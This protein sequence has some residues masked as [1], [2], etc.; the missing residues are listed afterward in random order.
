M[1]RNNT[2]AA[3]AA[4]LLAAPLAAQISFG[5]RPYGDKAEKRGMPP[6]VAVHLPAVDVATLLNEDA[7]RAS[8]GIKGPFR[9]GFEH[10]TDL[11]MANSG[12]WWTM[13]NGDRVWRVVLHCPEALTINLQFSNYVLPEGAR[14][15]IY[16]EAGEVKGAFTAQSNP[17]HTAFGTVPLAGDRQTVEYIEPANSAEHGALTISTVIHGYRLLGKS[18]ERSFGNSG[19]CNVNT[20]CPEGDDWR[21]EIRAVAHVILGGGVCSGSLVNNC[22]NDSTPYFLTA[23]HCTG[24]NN[25][26]AS[27]VFVF[28]WESPACTPTANAPMDHSIT[29]CD[30][31][32]ENPPTDASF[33][34]LSTRPPANFHPYYSGWDKSGSIPDTVHCIHH[35]SGDIK[36]ISSSNGPFDA[37]NVNVGNGPADCWHVPQWNSGT[38]EPGSSGSSLWNQDHR[39][40][41]QLYGGQ[42]SCNNNVNDFFGRFDSTYQH[43]S[44]WLGACGQTLDGLDPEL[45]IP[46][47]VDAAITSITHVDRVLCN[48]DSVAP[49]VTLKNNGTAVI[50]SAN[51]NYFINGALQGTMPWYGALQPVQTVNVNLPAIHF[52]SGVHRLLISVSNPNAEVDAN[53]HNDRD[54][55]DLMVNSPGMPTVVQLDLDR[56]G[57]ETRWEIATTGG[58]VAYSG[59]PYT[60]SPNGY[61]VSRQ[62]CLIPSCYVFTITD[63]GGDGICCNFGHGDYRIMDTLGTVL[64]DGNGSFTYSQ[65]D[66][67]CVNWVGIREQ[68]GKDGLWVAPNPGDGHF[69]LTL[70]EGAGLRQLRVQDALGR[71]VWSG[72]TSG[73]LRMHIDL[74]HLAG[75]TYLLVAEG[76]GRRVVQ[77]IMVQH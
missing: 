6:A 39:I 64:L 77:R 44:Q 40:I 71:T 45:L 76:E 11:T 59:G 41:G 48:T 62:V 8:E 66:A 60:N 5:G 3:L 7:Q 54:S 36:K 21:Q 38:T 33:L 20:I 35:P 30:K 19:P 52:Q 70:P 63:G 23:N 37:Q 4:I 53:P 1:T 72:D 49:I 56:F 57:A 28:N 74:A 17:G 68:Q 15:F 75:G 27:W 22:A 51:I 2:L 29:G 50:T 65:S 47:P 18:E 9:F 55:L 12:S 46:L 43:I 61:T 31:L 13:P 32:F 67:F 42:A 34:R 73:Q 24:G 25:T 14:M 16:N 10:H 26:N 58:F 69:S